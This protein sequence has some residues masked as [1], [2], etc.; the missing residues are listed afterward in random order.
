[1][2]GVHSRPTPVRQAVCA[3]DGKAGEMEVPRPFGAK[4]LQVSPRCQTLSH[5]FWISL[6]DLGWFC[7]DNFYVLV[8]SFCNKKRIICFF[9]F[10]SPQLREAG[11]PRR[12]WDFLSV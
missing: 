4:R 6:L 1:M 2:A 9:I 12:T 7:L 11:F 10:R 8:I 5:V 3:F